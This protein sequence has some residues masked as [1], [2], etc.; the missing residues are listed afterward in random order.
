[1]WTLPIYDYFPLSLKSLL[2]NSTCLNPTPKQNVFLGTTEDILNGKKE[3]W[4][5]LFGIDFF[6]SQ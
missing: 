5:F 2:C 1:M 4:R 6:E 3:I